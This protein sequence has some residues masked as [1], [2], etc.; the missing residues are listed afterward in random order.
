MNTGI[1]NPMADSDGIAEVL[2]FWFAPGMENKWFK[3]DPAFDAE[4][5]ARLGAPQEN[6][7]AGAFGAWR[8]SA[9]GCLA[10]V[11]LLDQVPRN[12]FRGQARA[13]ATDAAAREL[14]GHTLA[15][16]FE[17]ALTQDQRG[18]L[19]MPL[20]HSESLEDQDLSLRLTA[21]LDENPTWH[22]WAVPHRNIIARFGRFPH[23]NAALGRE[24]T[25]E[26]LAFLEQP[27]S[28]F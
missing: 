25:P 22:R 5:R 17:A 8:D 28:S 26:E 4:V 7:V 27:N 15:Q 12:L 23:R 13:F 16:G 10:L 20:Q 2:G 9:E 3:K 14:T 21:R 18:F 6:A 24:S 11:V 1:D 19:Y